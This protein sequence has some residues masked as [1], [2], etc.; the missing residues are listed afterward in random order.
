LT[1]PV[2]AIAEFL[3]PTYD[4]ACRLLNWRH[5]AREGMTVDLQLQQPGVAG[6]HP[7][8][9]IPSGRERG[10]RFLIVVR[11]PSENPG[12]GIVLHSG[13]VILDGWNESDRAGMMARFVL[14]DGPDGVQGR[15]PFF[16]LAIG[17]ARGEMLDLVAYAVSEDERVVGPSKVRGR[18][19]FH[20]LTEVTQSHIL[21][22][23]PRFQRF[24][25]ARLERLV[26]DAPTREALL[27]MRDRPRDFADGA[28][29]AALGVSTRAVMN[30]DGD[31]AAQARSRWR[32]LWAANEDEAFD[33][34]FRIPE[35]EGA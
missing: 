6:S 35:T 19:P 34:R 25:E 24:L 31:A 27:A 23:D 33:R 1:D 7:F 2:A 8:R 9:G 26:R 17:P 30:G 3:P 21:C 12:A 14:D 18:T 22:G 10:Q 5:G 15:H 29:R 13:E 20:Q 4:G 16:G 28:V 11:F 32:N